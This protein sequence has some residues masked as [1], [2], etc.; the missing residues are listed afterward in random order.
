[1]A[2]CVAVDSLGYVKQSTTET[3]DNCTTYVLYTAQ[4]YANLPTLT[5]IFT[6]PLAE[7]LGQMWMLGFSMPIIAYLTAWGY[8]VVINWFKEKHP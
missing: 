4:D 7:D 1:M 2:L 5:D 8:G 3:I 6:M